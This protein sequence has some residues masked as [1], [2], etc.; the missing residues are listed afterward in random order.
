MGGSKA[1]QGEKVASFP[2]KPTSGF[3]R[4]PRPG[5]SLRQSQTFRGE[6]DGSKDIDGPDLDDDFNPPY[7]SHSPQGPSLAAPRTARNQ[8]GD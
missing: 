6:A 3:L 8:G 7:A 4:T 5:S 1:S 2:M